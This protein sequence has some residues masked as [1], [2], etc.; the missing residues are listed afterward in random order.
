MAF[1][2]ALKKEREDV[3]ALCNKVISAI[4]K[5]SKTEEPVSPGTAARFPPPSI[6]EVDGTPTATAI[7]ARSDGP[8]AKTGCGNTRELDK[9]HQYLDVLLERY[10]STERVERLENELTAVRNL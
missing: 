5:V 7:P 8:A 4:S 3:L 6:E 10:S 1:E 2:E 9:G